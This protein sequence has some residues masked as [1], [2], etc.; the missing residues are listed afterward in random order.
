M[1]NNFEQ[2]N[3]LLQFIWRWKL[4][5]TAAI[6][7]KFFPLLKPY[8]AYQRLNRLE[9]NGFIKAVRSS[10]D[11]EQTWT[12]T[13]K[14]FSI[15]KEMLPELKESGFK[16]EKIDH[17]QI[18]TAVHLG[19][20]IFDCRPDIISFTEQELR[21]YDPEFYP[22][23]IPKTKIHRPDGYWIASN[24]SQ[25][26]LIAL[27]VELSSKKDSDY[28][29]VAM[30]YSDRIEVCDVI[31]IVNNIRFA[32]RLE[33][34]LKDTDSDRKVRH[35][36]FIL[37]DIKAHGWGA[38]SKSGPKVDLKLRDILAD[39]NKKSCVET[40]AILARYGRDQDSHHLLFDFRKC[41]TKL[42]DYAR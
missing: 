20:Q 37:S 13:A 11:S 10:I 36:F 40:G 28:E 16:S 26:K 23:Q 14:G 38:L 32:T 39:S 17:D 22:R 24:G 31:W 21:R 2:R 7:A 12:L 30:F 5:S 6:C 29:S 25:S 8:S 42:V 34:I 3:E 19:E 18:V 35:S 4:L 41:R 15:V 27:E 1:N 33:S 9:R